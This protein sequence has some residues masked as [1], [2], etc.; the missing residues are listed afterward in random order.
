MP[1][2]TTPGQI[3]LIALCLIGTLATE[4]QE[5]A[6]TV[7]VKENHSYSSNAMET[8]P[9]NFNGQHLLFQSIRST[10]QSPSGEYLQLVNM[11]TGQVMSQFGANFSFGS[12]YVNGNEINVF[13][14]KLEPG[15]W[16]GD[17]YRFTSTDG[18]N[19]TAPSLVIARE[20]GEYL[21]NSSVT[22]GPQGYVMAYESNQPIQFDYKFA[23]SD[24]LA[25]WTKL[26]VPVFAGPNGNEYSACPALRYSNGYYYSLYL[27]ATGS[28][29]DTYIARSADLLAWEYS[30]Q[31]PV[32]TASAGE[33]NNNS[34]ADLFEFGGKTYVYYGKVI[35]GSE[36]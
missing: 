17:I 12:A 4:Q 28:G 15:E 27:H 23:R 32:L 35:D 5:A 2:T 11:Q 21:F 1:Y 7:L 20:N 10:V 29:W 16:T 36:R 8:T 19:W 9:I 24:D 22:L 34:D 25:T 6:A 33:G 13:A 3:C 14:T 18:I 26:N 31:N 30:D